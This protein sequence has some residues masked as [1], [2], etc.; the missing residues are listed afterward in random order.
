MQDKCSASCLPKQQA[1]GHRTPELPQNEEQAVTPVCSNLH[2]AAQAF[3]LLPITNRRAGQAGIQQA[4]AGVSIPAAKPWSELEVC[5]GANWTSW[6]GWHIAMRRLLHYCVNTRSPAL[7]STHSQD[8]SLYNQ[9][10]PDAPAVHST[11][12]LGQQAARHQRW[13]AALQQTGHKRPPWAP[14]P[15][16]KPSCCPTQPPACMTPPTWV[17][18]NMTTTGD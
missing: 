15:S 14:K 5:C 7:A 1:D 6:T 17:T 9:R 13:A 3:R 10:V 4:M 12:L 2:K 11:W 16:R 18:Y 8:L